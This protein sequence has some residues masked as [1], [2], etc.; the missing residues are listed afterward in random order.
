M[1]II[2]IAKVVAQSV[3]G[4]L[5]QTSKMPCKSISLPTEACQTGYRMAQIKGSICSSCYADKGFYSMYANTIKPAQFSRLDAVWNALENAENATLWVSGMVSLIG[6]DKYF[7]W[8]DSGDLQSVHHLNLIVLVARETPDCE[9]WLPTREYGMVKQYIAAFGK[10]A[11]PSNLTI[12]LSAMYPDQPVKIPAS[13]EGVKGIA[14]SNV[15][16]DKPI[17]NL[18]NAPKQGGAC[19]DC[20]MCWSEVTVSYA[21][22]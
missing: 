9:H 7:R 10:D 19:L 3:C 4:S 8:H 5:T 14:V 18:C 15:H 1:K 20:R 22:H 17:G 16:T 13:L 6:K 2:P 11:I 12:R 21:L